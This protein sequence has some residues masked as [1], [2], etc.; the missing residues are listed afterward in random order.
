MTKQEV[1]EKITVDDFGLLKF[2]KQ[3]ELKQLH[4]KTKYIDS[5]GTILF[6]DANKRLYLLACEEILSFEAKTMRGEVKD[7]GKGR[8]IIWVADVFSMQTT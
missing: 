7:D 5:N 1:K 8:K 6:K 2:G 4:G 3:S